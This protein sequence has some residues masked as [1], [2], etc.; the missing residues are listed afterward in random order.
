MPNLKRHLRTRHMVEFLHEDLVKSFQEAVKVKRGF[1]WKPQGPGHASALK[2]L[3]RRTSQ[4]GQNLYKR[5]NC[6]SGSKAG[7][8]EHLIPLTSG[9]ETED[10]VF[11]LV[12]F[13]LAL[14]QYFL[15]NPSFLSFGNDNRYL[16]HFWLKVYNLVLGFI[17]GC[18]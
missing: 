11:A 14:F 15:T 18:Y 10:L 2:H 13:C 7:K 12:G 9:T 5:V 16:C 17:G 6:V 4:R 3:P 1:P 8:E